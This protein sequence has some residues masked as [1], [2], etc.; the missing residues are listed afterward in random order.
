MLGLFGDRFSGLALGLEPGVFAV[1]A[2]VVVRHGLA[3]GETTK[4][5]VG[6]AGGQALH[7]LAIE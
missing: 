6:G 7:F 2:R 3:D 4:P 5:L 1:G